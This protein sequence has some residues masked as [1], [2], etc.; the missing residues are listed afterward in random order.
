[1]NHETG[2]R[3]FSASATGI[4]YEAPEL[5]PSVFD[6]LRGTATPVK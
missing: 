4:V 3:A 1:M 5:P 6:T 2:K